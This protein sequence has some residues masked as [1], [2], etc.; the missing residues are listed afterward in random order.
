MVLGGA[1]VIGYTAAQVLGYEPFAEK[2]GFVPADIRSSP[3][4]YR[5]FHYWHRGYRGG[6]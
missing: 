2:Q 3:G 5:S 6:K 1:L 4:G